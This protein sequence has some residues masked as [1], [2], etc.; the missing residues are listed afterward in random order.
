[1]Q[2]QALQY[3]AGRPAT[4]LVDVSGADE[5]NVRM[6]TR[7]NVKRFALI[8]VGVLVLWPAFVRAAVTELVPWTYDSPGG[9]TV[10]TPFS[11]ESVV[12][13]GTRQSPIPW[14]QGPV[15]YAA[16]ATVYTWAPSQGTLDVDLIAGGPGGA[17]GAGTGFKEFV[18][19]W[20]DS[21]DFVAIGLI[22]DPF[23][24][25]LCGPGQV[26]LMIEGNSTL[27]PNGP[28][29][30]Y[31]NN[32]V[33]TGGAHHFHFQWSATQLTVT[34]DNPNASPNPQPLV[35]AI[36]M[37]A[38]SISFMSAARLPGDSVNARFQNI[39]FG[40]NSVPNPPFRIIVPNGNPYVRFSSPVQ[41]SGTG[42]GYNAYLHISDFSTGN[43]MSV[44]M[45]ADKADLNSQGRPFYIIQRFANGV[46]DFRLVRLADNN[47]HLL[48]LAW[49]DRDILGN[50][51]NIA[52]FYVD[53]VP[54]ASFTVDLNPRLLFAVY[55]GARLN[56][57][58]VLANYM[59]ALGQTGVIVAFD[60]PQC[61]PGSCDVGTGLNANWNT[62]VPGD[63]RC[64]TFSCGITVTS[65][66]GLQLG[67]TFRIQGTASG[68]PPGGDWD[69]YMVIGQA[70]IAEYW[71]GQ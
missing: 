22:H 69:S 57:D 36:K 68:I 49:W 25:P 61:A 28:I 60:R 2:V 11:M 4:R 27:G 55:A 64:A 50:V 5:E 35:Y 39:V 6:T 45:Q 34:L 31:W 33:I 53:N 43:A 17:Y 30:G 41:V 1:L 58:T 48:Q 54:I 10:S 26:T 52:V 59:S 14:G 13:T 16:G 23:A 40:D 65:W 20:N 71:F 62:S 66:N 15:N 8:A 7:P 46:F 21:L 12:M 29:G 47:P 44:G 63:T 51:V 38:P 67:G 37:N 19:F 70:L 9:L 56:G 18:Q 42:T 3:W 24:C 32:V